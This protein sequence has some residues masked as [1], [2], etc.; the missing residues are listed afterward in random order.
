M[1]GISFHYFHNDVHCDC[2]GAIAE[3]DFDDF[4]SRLEKKY[5]IVSPEEFYSAYLSG[6]REK[7]TACICF[8]CGL[9]SQYDIAYPVLKEHGLRAFWFLYTGAL[10]GGIVKIEQYH[11]FRFYC[12]ETIMDFYRCFFEKFRELYGDK[13]YNECRKTV[14]ETGY[15]GWAEYYTYEDKL[16]KFIR[17]RQL[18][19]SEFDE[20]MN[21]LMEEKSY[22]VEEHR[23]N[24]WLDEKE[25]KLLDAE[26]NMIGLHT[27][28]HPYD[29]GA[30]PYREQYEEY[31]RN[32]DRLEQIIGRSI[33]CMSHPCNSYNEDTLNILKDLGIRLGFR[34][35]YD[36]AYDSDLEVPRIDHAN[37]LRSLNV[38]GEEDEHRDNS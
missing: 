38:R 23:R 29:I 31:S 6:K 30:M 2:Q 1:H 7:D 22:N 10:D 18:E 36:P 11:H 9:K 15:L 33:K 13:A 4:L 8:D 3:K 24:L 12:Y 37:L 32:K 26:G 14:N 21:A 20:I 28:T 27:H 5:R 19:E 25:I 35:D 34:A 16:Y 17:N